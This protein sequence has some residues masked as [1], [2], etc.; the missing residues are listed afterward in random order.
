MTTDIPDIL[1]KIVAHKKEEV[2][3]AQMLAPLNE[4]KTRIADL[5]DLPR[6]FERHLREAVAS[7]WTAII[8]EVKKGSPS[9]GVIRENFDP[10][11]IAEIYQNN[12]ATCLSVLTD[13]Q[14]FGGHLRY[15]ALIRETASLPLLR[16]DFICDP[17]Q[18]FEARAAGADAIL[19][20]AAM[21]DLNQLREFHA[22][23][24]ELHLDVLLEVHDEAEMETALQTDCTLIGINNRNLRTFTMDIDTTGRLAQMV[25]SGRLLVAES[26]INSRADIRRLH[27]DG[28]GAFLIGEALMRET[29]IG[30]KLQELLGD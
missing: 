13:E 11:K 20:I 27:D 24:R 4:L 25:P 28:A 26:G 22:V 1:K 17:Y 6:G 3:T 30:A 5:E 8:A 7:G 2:A 29:D 10:L 23:A 15:L 21:L 12:G 18:I 16:K 9:K 19:L 14:F